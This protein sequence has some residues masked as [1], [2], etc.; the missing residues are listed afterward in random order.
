MIDLLPPQV[1]GT[2][3][4]PPAPSRESIPIDGPVIERLFAEP[5]S[6]DFF[7]A[8]CLLERIA[9]VARFSEPSRSNQRVEPRRPVGRDGGPNSEIVR[10]RVHQAVNFPASA[11]Y[12]LQLARPD[13]PPVMTVT[14][15]GLTGPAGV[16][17]R[18]YTELLMRLEREAKSAEKYAL[19]DWLDLFNHRLISLFH[20]AWEKYRFYVPYARGEYA[21]TEP[22]AFTTCLYSLVGLGTPTLRGRLC[23]SAWVERGGQPQEQ[24][25]AKIEDLALLYY[26]GLLAQRPRSAVNLQALVSDYFQVPVAVRQFEGQW[27]RLDEPN[28][29]RLGLEDG[30]SRLGIDCVVGERVWDIQSK[31]RL[32]LGP[33]TYEQFLEFLPDRSSGTGASPGEH[34]RD[35][36]ATGVADNR[37]QL[38]KAFFLLS[39]LVRLFVGP[40]LDFDVQLI[41]QAAEVPPCRLEGQAEVGPRL[42]W[43]TWLGRHPQ[44]HDARDAFFPGEEARWLV[45]GQ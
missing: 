11:I 33:L 39:H 35:A 19:R 42:G 37:G 18:H 7:Q 24:R 21:R 26:G 22:D 16:L 23:T 32:V 25:L 9:L 44:T 20:R 27:L 45:S 4:V 31:I 41:L 30:N 43:N 14:F 29:S 6:F 34:R 12:D 38:R 2:L 1:A 10:F 5:W 13:A 3:R 40:E 28:Q 8:V 17:P 15:M 36:G